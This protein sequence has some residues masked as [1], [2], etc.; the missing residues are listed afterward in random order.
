MSS[1]AF[2]QAR[3][4]GSTGRSTVGADEIW[5]YVLRDARALPFR[6]TLGRLG[7]FNVPEIATQIATGL[8]MKGQDVSGSDAGELLEM[9][10]EIGLVGTGAE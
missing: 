3:A 7:I 6:P 2:P 9:V 8:P 1:I 4:D 5:G 10:N